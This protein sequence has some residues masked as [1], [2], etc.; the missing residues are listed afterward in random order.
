[1]SSLLFVASAGRFTG[2]GPG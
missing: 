2:Y 1:M